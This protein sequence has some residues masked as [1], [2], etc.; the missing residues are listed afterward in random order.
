MRSAVMVVPV[1]GGQVKFVTSKKAAVQLRV[2]VLGYAINGKPINVR[3]L[4]PTRIAKARLEAGATLV[5][6]PVTGVGG[7]PRKKKPVTG[8]ILQM[9]TKAK[10]PDG[11]SLKAYGLD[12]SPPGSRSAPIVAGKWYTSLVVAEIGTDG[13]IVLSSS[14]AA[15][16]RATIVGYVHR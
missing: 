12:R 5:L 9:R 14:V 2:E 4:A 13:K 11:G 16:V 7:V 15:R 8:V 3:G 6:G 1:S 10:G